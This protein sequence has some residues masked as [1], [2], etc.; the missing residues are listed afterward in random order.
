VWNH[1]VFAP[2]GRTVT[3]SQ[4]LLTGPGRKHARID[5]DGTVRIDGGGVVGFAPAGEALFS[6]GGSEWWSESEDGSC[7]AEFDR[8]QL[9]CVIRRLHP[10]TVAWDLEPHADSWVNRVFAGPGGLVVAADVQGQLHLLGPEPDRHRLLGAHRGDVT[11]LTWSPD[12]RFL[13]VQ[14]MGAVRVVDRSGAIVLDRP[15]SHGVLPGGTGPELLL[16]DR[17]GVHSFNAAVRSTLT[18]ARYSGGRPRL[19]SRR[20]GA[21]A[22]ARGPLYGAVTL[23]AVAGGWLCSAAIVDKKRCEYALIRDD[24]SVSGGHPM[25]WDL[26]AGDVLADAARNRVLLIQFTMGGSCFPQRCY[27]RLL[28]LGADGAIDPER[29]FAA[30]V[31]WI[32][33]TA[34]RSRVL[35]GLASNEI[36]ELDA[37]SL[38]E[39]RRTD[40]ETLTW[41]EVLDE[42]RALGGDGVEAWWFDP[43]TWERTPLRLAEAATVVRAALSP[44]KKHVALAGDGEVWIAALE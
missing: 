43:R 12:G 6:G 41:L 44:D 26:V 28:V 34:D 32:T 9:S 36:L 4:L 21:R 23:Q 30:S 3:A 38:A 11:G 16:F 24:G 13:A 42:G 7:I 18:L 19:V 22:G 40:V 39:V 29:E 20:A 15:G 2:D 17:V 10:G 27:G 33:F 31:L 5:R 8:K 14:G 35:L 37:D 1:L 25:E